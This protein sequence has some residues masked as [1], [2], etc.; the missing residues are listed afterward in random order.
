MHIYHTHECSNPQLSFY[1]KIRHKF[2]PPSRIW[3]IYVYMQLLY[4]A[5]TYIIT[6]VRRSVRGQASGEGNPQRSGDFWKYKRIFKSC[7][8]RPQYPWYPKIRRNIRFQSR[9]AF[10]YPTC[11]NQA[12]CLL[13]PHMLK[14]SATP[15]NIVYWLVLRCHRMSKRILQVVLFW[16]L[17]LR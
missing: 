1:Q 13:K 4:P 6:N 14:S 11:W 15:C 7:I 2:A 10:S 8:S 3:Y 5:L 9:I 12:P 17:A 16:Y